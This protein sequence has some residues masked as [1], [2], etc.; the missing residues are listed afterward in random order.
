[1][2]WMKH[3]SRQENTVYLA[4]WGMLFAAPLFSLYIRSL[5]GSTPDFDW[6]EAIIVWPQFAIYLGL[7][8]VHNFL[9]APLLV[10]RHKRLI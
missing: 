3:Q 5:N 2:Y 9:L 1:M 8:L 7:F 4:L 10:F 6:S